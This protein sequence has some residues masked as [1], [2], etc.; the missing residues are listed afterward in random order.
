MKCLT[1]GVMAEASKLKLPEIGAGRNEVENT[2]T[3]AMGKRVRA[4]PTVSR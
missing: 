3:R 2:E 1:A 4:L